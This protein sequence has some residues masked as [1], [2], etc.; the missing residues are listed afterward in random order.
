MALNDISLT[1]GMRSN[2]LS[3]QSTTTLLDRTQNRLATGKKVNTAL[4]NPTNFFAAQAHSQRASD[5]TSRKDGMMEAVQGVTAADKGITAISALIEAARGLTQAARSATVENRNSLAGQYN[6]IL[7]QIDKLAGDSGYKGKNFLTNDSLTVLFNENG[8]SSLTIQGFDATSNGLAINNLTI[9]STSSLSFS[10]RVTGTARVAIHKATISTTLGSGFASTTRVIGLSGAASSTKIGGADS[11]G[12]NILSGAAFTFSLSGIK[13]ASGNAL[14]TGAV[15]VNEIYA[16]GV[17]VTTMFIK[18]SGNTA[19]A[20][21]FILTISTG[22]KVNGLLDVLKAAGQSGLKGVTGVVITL[23]VTIGART[24]TGGRIT[25]GANEFVLQAGDVGSGLSILSGY[26]WN[27]TPGTAIDGQTHTGVAVF[28]DGVYKAQS[29]AWKIAT[30]SDGISKI[31]KFGTGIVPPSASVTYAYNSGYISTD[32]S[33]STSAGKLVYGGADKFTIGSFN[34]ANMTV[35]NVALDGNSLSGSQYSVGSDGV[36]TV[37]AGVKTT[38]FASKLTYDLITRVS[39]S[40]DSNAG[41]E[42]A[43]NQLTTAV[44]TLRTQTANLSSNMNIVTIRKDF[45]DG[46]INTLLK[47]A[48]NLTL[49]DM[50]EEGANMLMLQTRQQLSTTSLK[51]ASDAAQAVLRLF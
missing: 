34:A 1:A 49:A 41:I 15:T 8:G 10:G 42:Y 39:G 2:L 27:G 48:D 33:S 11:S 13:G 23:D 35:A 36:L 38:S 3:L 32:T 24:A 4:D 5:L 12:T 17:K 21:Q 30:G 29:G 43:V 26:K 7:G 9:A 20:G 44:E 45:T 25:A 31:I 14:Y 40:W 19:T 6:L 37:A 16:N 18:Y 51:M 28:V 46:M 47:G 50:N 22:G